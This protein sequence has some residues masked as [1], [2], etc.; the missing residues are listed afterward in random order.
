MKI[1]IPVDEMHHDDFKISNKNLSQNKS[2]K[3]TVIH[4]CII[5]IGNEYF[6]Q[7]SLIKKFSS[8]TVCTIAHKRN[9]NK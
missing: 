2:A 8:T 5:D 4:T 1:K 7:Y 9:H 6:N 3:Y